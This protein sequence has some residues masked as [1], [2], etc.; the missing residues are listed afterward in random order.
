MNMNMQDIIARLDD[1]AGKCIRCGFCEAVC[2]TLQAKSYSLY[3]GPRGRVILAGELLRTLQEGSFNRIQLN[4]GDAVYSCLECFLCQEICPAGVNA[5]NVSNVAKQIVAGYENIFEK[6]QEDPTARTLCKAIMKYK[7]PLGLRN[8]VAEWARQ[9]GFNRDSDTILYTGH[10]YQLMAYTKRLMGSFEKMSRYRGLFLKITE[11][12]PTVIRFSKYFVD[13]DFKRELE[14]YLRNIV[15]LLRHAGVEFTYLGSEEPYP[16]TLLYEFGH[17]PEFI[18]YATQ[19]T[20]WLSSRGVKKIIVLDPHTYYIFDN[21]YRKYVQFDFEVVYYLDY[22]SKLEFKEG[23]EP[24]TYHEPC[25]FA[26]KYEYTLPKEILEKIADVRYPQ[27]S[28]RNSLCCGGPVE[29]LFPEISKSISDRRF[30]ELKN[31][32]AQK[33]ITACPI[34]YLNLHKDPTVV[35]ISEFLI[36]N[37]Q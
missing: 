28:G 25:I 4:I 19:I 32:G 20:E 11:K 6:P 33:I 35:D 37:L 5:G 10:M 14:G 27:H 2:P 3:Y 22:L 30:K 8:E 12:I 15:T 7:N 13:K 24:I 34:C 1:E 31:T 26:R 29:S 9:L 36:K 23:N 17:I 18:D 16:G 21:I